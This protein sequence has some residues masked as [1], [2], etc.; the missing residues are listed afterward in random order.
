MKGFENVSGKII[1][2]RHKLMIEGEDV[3]TVL[4]IIDRYKSWFINTNLSVEKSSYDDKSI[5]L[6]GFNASDEQF[7]A[8]IGDLEGKELEMIIKYPNRVMVTKIKT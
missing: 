5:W 6:V 7:T 4:E 2:K 3:L 1:S 8:I